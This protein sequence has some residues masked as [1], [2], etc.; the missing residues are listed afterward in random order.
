MTMQSTMMIVQ[1][2]RSRPP[3]TPTETDLQWV[4][5]DIIHIL[6]HDTLVQY[7]IMVH[8]AY[9]QLHQRCRPP[10]TRHVYIYTVMY[11]FEC[12]IKLYTL[13]F[14]CL[15]CNVSSNE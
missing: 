5:S 6:D 8:D 3:T 4:D 10:T 7:D 12:F 13:S 1:A 14:D 11:Y 2:E 9:F 15:D